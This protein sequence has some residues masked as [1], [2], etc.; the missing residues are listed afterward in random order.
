MVNRKIDIKFKSH[1]SIKWNINNHE[2]QCKIKWTAIHKH[3][4]WFWHIMAR[5]MAYLEEMQAHVQPI[6]MIIY[7]NGSALD[8]SSS[9]ASVM[10]LLLP[11][12]HTSTFGRPNLKSD[13]CSQVNIGS[14]YGLAIRQQ[15]IT[16]A[17]VDQDPCRHMASPGPNELIKGFSLLGSRDSLTT[18]SYC[19]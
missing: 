12:T 3:H 11:C 16:W 6:T 4:T 10:E 17:N 2:M 19:N 8:Y 14:V 1:H 13:P 9:S 15:D 18:W 7:I 5:I